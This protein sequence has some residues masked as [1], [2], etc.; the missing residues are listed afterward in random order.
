MATK[1]DDTE[2]HLL[3]LYVS[4]CVTILVL[5]KVHRTYRQVSNDAGSKVTISIYSGFL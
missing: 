3:L 5:V 2:F 1:Y 4:Y